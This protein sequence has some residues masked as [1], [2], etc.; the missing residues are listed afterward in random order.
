MIYFS[1]FLLAI[2]AWSLG[3]VAA[4][5][6]VMLLL[7]ILP[8]FIAPAQVI[9]AIA[10]GSFIANPYRAFLFI[11]D[12]NWR[13]G[14]WMVAGSLFGAILGSYIFVQLANENIKLL[15]GIFLIITALQYWFKFK[16]HVLSIPD[17]AF[18]PLS[19]LVSFISAIV[20]GAGPVYNPFL[21]AKQ[22]SKEAIVATKSINSLVMQLT[23]V[24]GYIIFGAFTLSIGGLGIAIG[25]GA[26]VG[27]Y[28]GKQFMNKINQRQFEVIMAGMMLL[29][30]IYFCYHAIG[31]NS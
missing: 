8:L 20:G 26:L 12:V 23:K 7:P 22:L 13:I 25:L 18:L 14:A 16:T 27:V 15:I 24:I 30:G 5:G 3:T 6:A 31:I 1:L 2:A 29:I 10:L 19:C 4:G 11:N 28:F 21:A 17:W 9:P